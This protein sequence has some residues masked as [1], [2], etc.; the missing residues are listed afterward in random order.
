MFTLRTSGFIVRYHVVSNSGL[1]IE[2]FLSAA[3]DIV[4]EWINALGG[5]FRMFSEI[6]GGIEHMRESVVGQQ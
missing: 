2:A 4:F 1:G 5:N 3:F 6:P